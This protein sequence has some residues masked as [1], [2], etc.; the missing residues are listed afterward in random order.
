MRNSVIKTTM[1]IAAAAGWLTLNAGPALAQYHQMNLTGYQPGMGRFLDPKLNGWGMVVAP[2]GSFCVAN[3]AT[4]VATFYD[5]SGKPLPRVITIPPAAN[6]AFGPL[7]TPTGLVY[8]PTDEFVI[9]KNGKSAPAIFI[10]NSLDGT[11][12]GWNPLVDQDAAV[13]IQDNSGDGALYTGLALGRNCRGQIVLYAANWGKNRVDMLGGAFNSLSSF[14]DQ[15]VAAELPRHNVF[16]VDNE[17]GK[18]YVTWGAFSP[19]FG[20]VVD[21]FDADGN[22]LTPNHFAANSPGGGPLVNPWAITFAP[23]HFGR[24]SH[25]LLIGN[26]ED[27]KINAFDAATAAFLG[28]LTDQEG[29]PIVIP[30]LW[31][32][33]FGGPH[34]GRPDQ[35][36]FNAGPNAPAFAGNGR[37]G[38]IQAVGGQGDTD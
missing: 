33:I 21:I 10:F 2:D 17:D 5:Q 37:F 28:P 38:V 16:G 15:N 8:N 35:L 29:A 14:S 6:H 30:G 9:S 22:L 24:F 36:F 31:E 20:G 18:I 26:V 11:I 12:S 23:N 3:T 19:P 7:G 27:G 34:G 1:A 4:G 32:L 13:T 25:A